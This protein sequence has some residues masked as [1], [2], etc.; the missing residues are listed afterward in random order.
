VSTIRRSWSFRKWFQQKRLVPEDL[1][2]TITPQAHSFSRQF[3]S[4]H[5]VQL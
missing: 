2:E 5:M 3:L 4:Q 1:E